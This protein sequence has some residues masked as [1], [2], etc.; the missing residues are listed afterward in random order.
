MQANVK[1]K[2]NLKTFKKIII[3]DDTNT[4][5]LVLQDKPL[6]ELKKIDSRTGEPLANTKF[7]I[8]K[9][10]KDGKEIDY[11]K[12]INGN[13]IGNQDENGDYIVVTDEYGKI[14]L[15]LE[16]GIYKAVEV[17]Y[18]EGYQERNTESIFKV[19]DGKQ[20]ETGETEEAEVIEINYIDDLVQL[21]QN[22]QNGNNYAGKTIKLM[23]NLDFENDAD[24]LDLSL[25]NN[26]IKSNGGVGFTP[27]GINN[28]K[29]FSGIF[30]GQNYEIK[31]L[32]IN[33][34]NEFVGLFG[35]VKNTKIENLSVTGEVTGNNT[36]ETY[37]S[38][39]IANAYNCYLIKHTSIFP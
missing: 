36:T 2:D 20:E 19:N 29:Y 28:E 30:D 1:N 34:D 5:I 32:Y 16:G 38:G 23:R 21:S 13:Y 26:L 10:D 37:T 18:P 14:V 9:I 11:A 3:D 6:F 7:I 35:S 39:I 15:P 33:S 24:Y 22:A 31:N 25:K 4:V 27:I 8:Y 12:D 17:G